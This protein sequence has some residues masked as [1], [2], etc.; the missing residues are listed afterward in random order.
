M[1][2]DSLYSKEYYHS[3]EEREWRGPILGQAIIDVLKPLSVIDIGFG[4][5]EVMR[6]LLSKGLNVYGIE[7]SIDAIRVSGVP[8]KKAWVFDLTLPHQPVPRKFDL[9][10]CFSV[11]E[12]IEPEY[13]K[14]FIQNVQALADRIIFSAINSF[15]KSDRIVNCRP[16]SYWEEAFATY[17]MVRSQTE[18]EYIRELVGEKRRKFMMKIVVD[19]LLFMR[20]VDSE[21]KPDYPGR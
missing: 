1:S 11:V 15:P 13:E 10:I 19:N 12:H 9:A 20:R 5:G 6:Y 14:N 18:E 16:L 3:L 4:H 21:S 8:T 7:R 17:G 2:R